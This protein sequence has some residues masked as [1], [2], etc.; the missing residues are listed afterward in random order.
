M[1]CNASAVIIEKCNAMANLSTLI[2]DVDGTLADTERD[3]H[4]VAFNLAFADA[5]LG[6]HWQ[7]DLYGALLTVAGGK[8]RIRFFVDRYRP[9]MP[10]AIAQSSN[11]ST[12]S[13]LIADLHQSKT[14]YYKQ[15]VRDGKILPRPG[16]V[17]LIKEA[18]AAGMRLAIATTSAPDN[19]IALLRAILG[20]DSPDWFEVIAAGDIVPAKKPAPDVYHYVL[21][22]MQ[23]SPEECLVFE[24]SEHGLRAATQAG[25]TTL[26]TINGYTCS[27]SFSDAAVVVK[28]LGDADDPTEAIAAPIDLPLGIHHPTTPYIDL[29]V[30]KDIHHRFT[31]T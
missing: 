31:G 29:T 9:P 11:D 6:W 19:A 1:N 4:R 7:E 10:A 23:V 30:L 24:D 22:A 28:H 14:R 8:E 2:F 3:G 18:R 21:Q 26:V 17:R 12:L 13:D 16:V 5:G 25:L 15:L 27:Q 20:A